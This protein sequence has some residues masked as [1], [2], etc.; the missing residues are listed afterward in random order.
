MF[1]MVPAALAMIFR[2]TQVKTP[3]QAGLSRSKGSSSK[4]CRP[5]NFLTRLA[6]RAGSQ[7][8]SVSF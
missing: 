6:V 3:V 8:L 7:H 1:G 4:L 2:A 5:I